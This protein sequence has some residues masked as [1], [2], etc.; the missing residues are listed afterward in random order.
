MTE[1]GEYIRNLRLALD[2]S[3]RQMATRLNITAGYLSDIERGARSAPPGD[4]LVKLAQELQQDP[5]ELQRLAA[6]SRSIVFDPK[7]FDRREM[8]AAAML[9]RK[10]VPLDDFFEWWS[11]KERK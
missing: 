8:E 9:A 1:F 6:V 10:E 5:I 4:L 11:S 7:L 2:I 3:L